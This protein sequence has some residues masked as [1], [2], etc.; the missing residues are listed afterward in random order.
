MS[1]RK[2]LR[3]MSLALV[4]ALAAAC[5]QEAPPAPDPGPA[6]T[7][8]QAVETA[9]TTLTP[10]QED[11]GSA[12]AGTAGLR[13][14]PG[15][16]G[17]MSL[18]ELVEPV[19]IRAG[20]EA[21]VT[22]IGAE[23]SRAEEVAVRGAIE[24]DLF[25]CVGG[26]GTSDSDNVGA[27]ATVGPASSDGNL[28]FILPLGLVGTGVVRVEG[29]R[30]SFTVRMD[31]GIID[32]DFDD[33]VLSVE[34]REAEDRCDFFAGSV[35]DP[36]LEDDAVQRALFQLFEASVPEEGGR[37]EMGGYIVER[38]DGLAFVPASSNE[39]PRVCSSDFRS[40]DLPEGATLRAHVH[41][42]PRAP[43]EAVPEVAS[44]PNGELHF[45]DGLG[46]PDIESA[47]RSEVPLYV[48]DADEV[49]RAPA[50]FLDPELGTG[51]SIQVFDRN[52]DAD[53]PAGDDDA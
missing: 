20:E 39:D 35:D 50:H 32:F 51:A 37:F 47:R 9:R 26:C 10:A 25:P 46:V 49:H 6:A 7:L 28:E 14:A 40:A 23:T 18:S 29:S 2:P 48:V 52:P 36:L 1:S 13:S 24:A 5:G 42:H 3:Y 41:T 22:V 11:S 8:E 43:G 4:V 21:V 44:C 33:V 19:P 30:P 12:T 27:T 16:S 53:C 34:L 45:G 31:D 38:D 15:V 17:T